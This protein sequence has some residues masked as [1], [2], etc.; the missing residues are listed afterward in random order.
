MAQD[1]FEKGVGTYIVSFDA[2]PMVK[3]ADVK[4]EI[5]KYKLEKVEVKITG[6]VV[7]RNKKY[8]A[9]SY[10]LAKSEEKDAEDMLAKV[11]EFLKAKKSVLVLV[12]IL[13]EDAKGIQ[14][15]TVTK[16]GEMDKKK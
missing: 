4:K 13:S 1:N 14:T 12:G 15:L 3:L 11:A 2:A 5:G 9:G 6:R 8:Y 10:L 7:E 16:V